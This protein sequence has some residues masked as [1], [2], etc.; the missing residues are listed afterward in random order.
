M[1]G[2]TA[3]PTPQPTVEPTPEPMSEP[4][5]APTLEP[6]LAPTPE[7][8]PQA[9]APFYLGVDLSY[10]NEMDDCGAAYQENGRSRDAYALF[11]EHGANLVRARLWHNPDWTNYST[12]AD[13]TRTFT[14]A[15]EAG[16]ATLLSIHY[17]DN[18]A[19]PGKQQIPAAWE[20]L[21]EAELPDALYQY[22]YDVL[23]QLHAQGVLPNFVQIGNE[24]NAGL[25]KWV[26][27]LDWPRDAQLFNAGIRAVR[28]LAAETNTHPQIVLH[29]AQP[30][31]ASW[32][33]R[34]AKQHGVTDFD[35]I[36]LSYY[37]QWSQL[38]PVDVGAFVTY[39]RQEYSK[40]VM[41]VE[42]AYP[43]TFDAVE[44]TADN[45]LNQ[46]IRGYGISVEGQRQFLVD[47]SQSLISNGGL[48]VVYW[49]PA[50]VST[51]CTTRWGQGSHWENATFFDFQNGNELHEGV[52]F[53]SYPYH[54]PV[55]PVDGMIEAS[56]GEPLLKDEAGDNFMQFNHLD[57][58]DLYV[59]DDA[60]SLYLAI[61]V[62]G[63]V[64]AAGWG[65]FMIYLDTSEDGQGAGVD[66][67]N[68]PITAAEP[69][70]PEFRLDLRVMDWKGTAGSSFEFYAWDGIEWQNPAL[71][72]G[73]AVQTG[74]PS[75]IELAL[76][77][78]LLG[79]PAFVN[80]GVV[81]TGRG[82]AHTAGDVLGS[83][84]LPTDWAEPVILDA[85]AHY[86]LEQ[87]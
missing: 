69:Y 78:A 77:K 64:Y 79:N 34:E 49:E 23:S 57:L 13:V 61:T 80:V 9:D 29:V 82:R 38:S 6:T 2:S 28:T 31:N 45:I 63:D 50:W 16:M 43:W 30:E 53:L 25:V 41:I 55:A 20:D 11:S 86:A 51:P 60:D 62:A 7:P 46:G 14:R 5:P 76:P 22:T 75:V 67:D 84:N 58:L 26:D 39:L 24:T 15:K 74:S 65:Q 44:E 12:L 36:G 73:A 40:E 32:W 87:R 33:F 1:G 70:Q 37:P 8:M 72:V 27:G 42:T 52:E 19:D 48:G 71:P 81:S 4:T 56:F 10:V 54:Y 66:V 35:V 85:L 83:S 3:V 68:R 18:W 47:L 21:T 59:R 17:S